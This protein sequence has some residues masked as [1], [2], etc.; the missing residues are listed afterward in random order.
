MQ[1]T[2]IKY[3]KQEFS[4]DTYTRASVQFSDNGGTITVVKVSLM[5]YSKTTTHT[6]THARTHVRTHTAMVLANFCSMAS[7]YCNI[8]Q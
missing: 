5:L 2:Y 8:S 6:H 3:W 7:K 4:R 1:A